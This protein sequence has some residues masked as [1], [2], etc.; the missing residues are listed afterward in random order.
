MDIKTYADPG[1]NLYPPIR[2]DDERRVAFANSCID[3]TILLLVWGRYF[4]F[5]EK[6]TMEAMRAWTE[7]GTNYFGR[8]PVA[9]FPRHT[10]YILTSQYA[11][12]RRDNRKPSQKEIV[13][14][15][16]RHSLLENRVAENAGVA[17]SSGD[18]VWILIDCAPSVGAVGAVPLFYMY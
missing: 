4:F 16:F 14:F 9:K 3:N 1:E 2:L 5:E 13:D 7:C 18:G 8:C 10:M 11:S 12:N 6:E 17:R 15:G